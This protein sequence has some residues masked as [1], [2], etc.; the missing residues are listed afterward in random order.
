MG[1]TPASGLPRPRA[2]ASVQMPCREKYATMR[3]GAGKSAGREGGNKDEG[4]DDGN[5][6]VVRGGR[7]AAIDATVRWLEEGRPAARGPTARWLEKRE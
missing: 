7:P 4:E 3:V 6:K 5:S 1:L 2:R